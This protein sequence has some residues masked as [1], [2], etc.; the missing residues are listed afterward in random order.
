MTTKSQRKRP[1]TDRH[2]DAALAQLLGHIGEQREQQCSLIRTEAEQESQ[3]LVAAAR[4]RAAGMLRDARR[5]ERAAQHARLRTARTQQHGSIRAVWLKLRSELAKRGLVSMN[6]ELQRLWN[7][8]PNARRCWLERSLSEAARVLPGKHW[9]LE[10][11]C[12]SEPDDLGTAIEKRCPGVSVEPLPRQALAA[13]FR[14][15]NGNAA[16]DLSPSGLL[17]RPNRIIGRLL[18]KQSSAPPE[19]EP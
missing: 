12:D 1:T 7:E 17:A 3:R 4:D 8:D 11:P 9:V 6:K 10:H 14:V 5:R 19:L 18:A 16:I 2:N 13:G 15:T